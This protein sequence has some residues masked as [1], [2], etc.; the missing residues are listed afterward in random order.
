MFHFEVSK[1]AELTLF[2][3]IFVL[4]TGDYSTVHINE[5]GTH[6]ML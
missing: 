2:G 4:V 1:G 3:E 6:N 5:L